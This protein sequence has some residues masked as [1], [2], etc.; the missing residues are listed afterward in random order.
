M[1]ILHVS[2]GLNNSYERDV[3]YISVSNHSLI[4]VVFS[5]QAD[6]PSV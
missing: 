6:A 5:H 4:N 2:F 1:I 3:L